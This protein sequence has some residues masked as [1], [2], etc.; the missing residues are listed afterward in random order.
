[1]IYI[2]TGLGNAEL[3]NPKGKIAG[4]EKRLM[5][6]ID[7]KSSVAEIGKKIPPSVRSHM[8]EIVT[9]LLSARF[10]AK[11]DKAG[12]DAPLKTPARISKDEVQAALMTSQRLNKN[13]LILA[14]V[15]IERRMELE[16]D[17]SV[18]EA[19]LKSAQT[20]LAQ[21]GTRLETV[22][23]KY[24][25]LKRQVLLYK[26]GMQAKLAALQTHIRK[27]SENNQG[28]Q[29]QRAQAEDDLN[30]MRADVEQMQVAVEKREASLDKTLKSRI[31]EEKRA[32]EEKRKQMK[33]EADEMVRA[34]PRYPEVRRLDFFKDFRNSDLAQILVWAEWREV[35]AGETVVVEGEEGIM[36]YVIVTGK[37][38]VVR[39]KRTLHVLQAGEPFGEISYLD[40]DD[41]RRSASVK[42]R[43]DCTLLLFNPAYLDGADL[44]LR[45]RVSEAFV[46]I[47]AKRL[48]KAV[49]MV[50]NLLADGEIE[51]D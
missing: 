41:P 32:E 7:G 4:D 43:T 17:L 21:A 36:F 1:M 47:Q 3:R 25:T 37:L 34:H 10:I 20:G 38:A 23:A 48:R 26:E 19:K 45:M 11:I 13:M 16:Q 9:S 18:A 35:K 40:D 42:A 51:N 22:T 27:C 12:T 30:R 15:E 2:R 39:G 28:N 6:L 5:L 29:A 44:M 50:A 24:E 31:R 8:D 14:E 46:R 49:E 33:I